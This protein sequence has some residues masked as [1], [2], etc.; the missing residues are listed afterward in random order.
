MEER[1]C[2][3]TGHREIPQSHLPA[4]KKKL[5]ETIRELVSQGFT[6]FEAGGALGFDTLAESTVL[7]LQKEFPEIQ[8]VLVLP[9]L[10]QAKS[11][12][13]QDLVRYKEI[14]RQ[15]GKE[16]IIYVS[17]SYHR[18]CMQQRNRRLVDDSE[19]C[20]A[21]CTQATGGTAYT[22]QYAEKKGVKVRNLAD[23]L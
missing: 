20:V 3:F 16:N 19:L 22:V 1:T 9:Y 18:G 12:K 2:C 11:W 13:M 6:R 15:V 23:A 14:L 7:S 17:Q 8:L 4:L 21:Y 5:E 10:Q